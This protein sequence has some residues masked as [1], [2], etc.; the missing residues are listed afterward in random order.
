M[1]LELPAELYTR[2]TVV[3]VRRTEPKGTVVR[4]ALENYLKKEEVRLAV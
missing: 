3:A 1:T 2:L 4:T